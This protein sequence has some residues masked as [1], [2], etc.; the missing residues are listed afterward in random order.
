MYYMCLAKT[1]CYT[2]N[3]SKYTRHVTYG[4]HSWLCNFSVVIHMR[5]QTPYYLCFE[6]RS[7]DIIISVL[8]SRGPKH[9]NMFS[10][11]GS[12]NTIISVLAYRGS[13]E[14]ITSVLAYRASLE[15]ITSV[16]T[17]RGSLET[18]TS[19]LTYIGD[20]YWI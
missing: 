18:I 4:V 20:D 17:Y 8:A 1:V 14:T 11:L 7:L 12:L 3:A 19:V 9:D 13:L 16:L 6:I 2:C 15:T 10:D 5:H